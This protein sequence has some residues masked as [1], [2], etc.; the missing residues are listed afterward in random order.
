METGKVHVRRVDD[1]D[2]D[3]DGIVRDGEHVRTNFWDSRRSFDA[4]AAQAEAEAAY[5]ERSRNYESA[6]KKK[7]PR[8]AKP[9]E[10]PWLTMAGGKRNYKPGLPGRDGGGDVRTTDV[11][12]PFDA[13]AAERE[14]TAAWEARNAELRDAYK[15]K[16]R[17]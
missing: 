3:D 14:A 2:D 4:A 10:Q 16:R 11:R 1:D 7:P 12:A 13:A 9:K 8:V 6:H 17:A 5:D 15:H